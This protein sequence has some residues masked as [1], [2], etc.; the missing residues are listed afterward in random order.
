M[1][2]RQRLSGL[3]VGQEELELTSGPIAR[4]LFYLSLPIVIT[5][6]LQVTYNL[7]DTF[8]L[9]QYST[10]ALAAITFGFPLVFLLI[11]LGMGLSVAGSVMVA[12]YTGAEETDEAEYAASQTIT[13]ALLFSALL[14][15]A[16]FF[17]VEDFLALIGAS[18]AVLPPATDYM[19]VVTLGL[20]FMFGFIVFIALMRGSGDTI[21]PML[22]ML[23]TVILNVAL[24]PFLIFGWG[25]FPELGVQGA[26]IATV[27][28]RGLAMAVGVG[29]M[30]QGRRG[31]QINVRDM[32]PDLSYA[33]RLLRIGIPAS[34][35]G[36][37]RAV[38]VN[39]LLVIVAT[40]SVTVEAAFGV[41]IRVFSTIFMPAIAVD[42]GVETMTGQNIGAD[43]PDRA[44]TA[45]HF[46]AK[47]SFVILAA[48]G[49]VTFV[50]A[51]AIM[52]LFSD[53]PAVIGEGANFLRIVAPT[54]GFM[55]VTRAYSGGFRGAGKVLT[56]AAITVLMLGL[57][58]LPIAWFGAQIY[59]PSGI[60]ASFAISN[61]L[62]AVVAYLW[63]RRGTW[64]ESDLTEDEGEGE[65]GEESELGSP[66]AATDD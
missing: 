26:A 55:G 33:R 46:A 39:L 19:E 54:F 32:V 22:V 44:A 37:G 51:P 24:D 15:L 40:F 62:A 29:I 18:G 16:G 27:F 6:L 7:A 48:L 17:L 49:V 45:N 56:A 11:S 14:G 30:V 8:W 25:P 13:F 43:K 2:I 34:V 9:G 10:V 53:N 21:T 28:S 50:A 66:A 5:N 64:R 58:R 3:F 65:G 60:W 59:G 52:G 23:G 4:P 20:P 12:Q 57:I 63:F 47:A 36:T 35:E 42:R 31:I 61:V 41:G 1:S 38:S